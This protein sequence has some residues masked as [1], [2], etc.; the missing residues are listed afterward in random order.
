MSF[1]LK[2]QYLRPVPHFL[3][4][5]SEVS[6]SE[7][8]SYG[9]GTKEISA[10]D[11][12]DI[13]NFH[14]LSC[15]NF[16]VTNVSLVSA[17]LEDGSLKATVCSPTGV[18]YQPN[19][20]NTMCL[21]LQSNEKCVHLVK[22][23]EIYIVA[24]SLE[25]LFVVDLKLSAIKELPSPTGG[26]M[27]F[28]LT[29][30][31]RG[32]LWEDPRKTVSLTKFESGLLHL[33]TTHAHIWDLVEAD[34]KVDN[35]YQI[36]RS[37]QV[38]NTISSAANSSLSSGSEIVLLHAV[39]SNE[40]LFVLAL[41]GLEFVLFRLIDT[42]SDSQV[43]SSILR[44]IESHEV[45]NIGFLLQPIKICDDELYILF[46]DCVVLCSTDLGMKPVKLLERHVLGSARLSRSMI[47]YTPDGIYEHVNQKDE[48][49]KKLFSEL[50][51]RF[52]SDRSLIK[53]ANFSQ[54]I[55]KLSP[56]RIL[57]LTNEFCLSILDCQSTQPIIQVSLFFIFY[58]FSYLLIGPI[59]R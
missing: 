11:P 17:E 52:L 44:K 36:R 12:A 33:T 31:A 32:I 18:F 21:S 34:Q 30:Y 39:F 23:N 9:I 51:S 47:F 3:K 8:I 6:S 57:E 38:L 46:K 49:E 35:I 59:A 2:T 41:V 22:Q 54:P 45:G 7:N 15:K 13:S 28:G 58:G 42:N 26:W 20:E 5:F 53:S 37:I 40:I 50:L 24:T 1:N 27:F 14:Y 29:R 19:Q 10:W 56:S 43:K 16:G 55:S 25:R 4:F 48:V